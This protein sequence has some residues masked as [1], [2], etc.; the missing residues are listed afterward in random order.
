MQ[1]IY[2]GR[3]FLLHWVPSLLHDL[4]YIFVHCMLI[5]VPSI[6]NER[7]VRW[8]FLFVSRFWYSSYE[9]ISLCY[10]VRLVNMCWPVSLI[11]TH[12]HTRLSTII[13]SSFLISTDR[14]ASHAHLMTQTARGR[15]TGSQW[16]ETVHELWSDPK[17]D[18]SMIRKCWSLGFPLLYSCVCSS[19]RSFTLHCYSSSSYTM[20]ACSSK[21]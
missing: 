8:A 7:A 15:Q 2:K 10:W 19:L 9:F 4:Q 13:C 16:N 18:Q 3:V 21:T 12:I 20:L 11:H 6:L 14:H 5:N 17:T 1:K